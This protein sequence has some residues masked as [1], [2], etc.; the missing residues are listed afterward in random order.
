MAFTY[1]AGLRIRP[2]E[3]M[4]VCL[5]G[6]SPQDYFSRV[7]TQ[8]SLESATS[9]ENNSG[10]SAP[11]PFNIGQIQ[12]DVARNAADIDTLETSVGDLETKVEN[13]EE[14]VISGS[15]AFASGATS[16]A[17]PFPNSGAWNVVTTPSVALAGYYVTVTDI[18]W[19][20]T[21]TAAGAA[22]TIQWVAVKAS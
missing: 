7:I 21:F 14:K 13:L 20:A 22:G 19:V 9:S 4:P 8:C 12:A 6:E 2:P 3:P 15:V 18:S 16:A 5:A 11:T 1:D 17:V 10:D